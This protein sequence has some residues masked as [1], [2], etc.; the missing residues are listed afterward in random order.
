MVSAN[1]HGPYSVAAFAG[2]P[3]G[4]GQAISKRADTP[5]GDDSTE[6]CATGRN[7]YGGY[8]RAGLHTMSASAPD[9]DARCPVDHG[10]CRA[11]ASFV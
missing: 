10:A 6:T 2:L 3:V 1:T 5:Y 8:T 11:V 7:E 4:G 9:G